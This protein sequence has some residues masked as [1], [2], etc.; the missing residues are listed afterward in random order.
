MKKALFSLILFFFGNFFSVQAQ[1]SLAKLKFASAESAF[2]K[3]DYAQALGY[4]EETEQIFGQINSPVLH[5]RILCMNELLKSLGNGFYRDE[6]TMSLLID[7]RNN[8]TLF[9]KRFEN[10]PDIDSKYQEVYQINESLKD[11]PTDRAAF[12]ETKRVIAAQEEAKKQEAE[13]AAKLEKERLAKEAEAKRIQDEKNR[14]QYE[15]EHN[16][17]L[18]DCSFG[19]FYLG[20]AL[21]TSSQSKENITYSDWVNSPNQNPFTASYM[22]GKPGLTVGLNLGFAGIV[23]LKAINRNIRGNRFGIG[24]ALDLKQALLFYSVK[25]INGVPDMH[26]PYFAQ[27]KNRPFAITSVGVGPDISIRLGSGKTYMDIYCRADLNCFYGGSYEAKIEDNVNHQDYYARGRAKGVKVNVSPTVGLNVRWIGVYLGFEARL[28]LN[29]KTEIYD[30]FGTEIITSSVKWD[31]DAVKFSN[32]NPM[33]FNY[34][35][36]NIGFPF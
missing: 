25:K 6:N 27:S 8:C 23:G 21:P 36:F 29:N 12:Q 13:R 20:I 19:G 16:N 5:L 2:N 10:E 33:N 4:L 34:I 32:K 3:G 24:I 14:L 17:Y 7:L 28:G 18:K 1:T 11:Y 30:Y 9:M 15:K 26:E 22:R 31:K 35:G